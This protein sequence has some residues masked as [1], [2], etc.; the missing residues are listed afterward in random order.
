M[1]RLANAVTAVTGAGG[2]VARQAAL[3]LAAEGSRLGLTELDASSLEETAA[4]VEGR[5]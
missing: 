3:R 2:G 5:G 1:A 4:L